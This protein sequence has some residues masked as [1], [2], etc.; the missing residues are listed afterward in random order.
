MDIVKK[1]T[2]NPLNCFA[3]IMYLL[4]ERRTKMKNLEEV[5]NK[6]KE[7]IIEKSEEN[8]IRNNEGKTVVKKDE[9]E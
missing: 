9:D 2:N 6:N 4:T 5:W 8:T 3:I 1:I 7:K